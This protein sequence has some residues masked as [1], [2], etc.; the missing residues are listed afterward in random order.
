MSRVKTKQTLNIPNSHSLC[1][2]FAQGKLYIDHKNMKIF[3]LNPCTF[4]RSPYI[5]SDGNKNP[6]STTPR[7]E[8]KLEARETDIKR[9]QTCQ[10]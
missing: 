9:S 10:K 8:T 4:Q 5:A 7:P 2:M 1:F 6:N 3:A